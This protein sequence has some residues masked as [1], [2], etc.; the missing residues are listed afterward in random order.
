MYKL[1]AASTCSWE[2]RNNKWVQNFDE[3]TCCKVATTKTDKVI[4][5]YDIAKRIE[6]VQD[7][8]LQRT[9]M[10]AEVNLRQTTNNSCTFH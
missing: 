3:K 10:L 8:V 6:L 1:Q 5:H 2:G 9:S 4:R 7:C